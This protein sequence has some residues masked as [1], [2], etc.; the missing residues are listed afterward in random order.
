V[1]RWDS[2]SNW[3]EFSGALQYGYQRIAV[4]CRRVRR[5]LLAGKAAAE[6]PEQLPGVPGA[7][8]SP[9]VANR[10]AYR[11]MKKHDLLQKKKPREAEVYQTQKLW[12][13]LPQRPNDLWQMDVT[14]IHIPGHGWWYAVTVI[15]YFSRY[16]LALHLTDSY[17]ALEV[18]AALDRARAEAE[19]LHGPL[20][21]APFIVTDNGPS[22]VAK[23]FAQF[24]KDDYTHV[25]I[26]YRTPT[27]LGLLE[28]FHQT[29]KTEE[30]YW[31]LY[32]NPAQARESLTLFRQRYNTTRPH[33]ALVPEEGGDPVTPEDVYVHGVA[34]QIPR[35][36]KWAT[37][38][39]EQLDQMLDK[40]AA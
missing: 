32:D 22:F 40:D 17:S 31:Q 35:W 9:H 36:Q 26:A 37:R 2:H 29:L 5:K 15:D 7:G 12:E 24:V 10:D 8:D 21:R 18:T 39:K 16:L 1:G 3:T 34:V 28:R 23:R 4:M 20:T 25:R 38:A 27:Q 13:L 33:W 14:Y 6:L 19:R 11:V 30:V